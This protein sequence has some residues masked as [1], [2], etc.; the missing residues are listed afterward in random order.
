VVK[1]LTAT[2]CGEPIRDKSSQYVVV[3]N[4][5]GI[6]S[7]VFVIQ[8]FAYK[9]WAKMEYGLD[10]WFTLLTIL[11]GVPTT[12]IN[13]HGVAPN[14]MGR[15][16]WTLTYEN[17][18]DFGRFFYILEIIYFA[19]V[20]LSKLAILFFYIRIFPSSGVRQVLWG[21]VVFVA[22]FGVAFIFSAIF[23]C[24]PIE[25]YWWKWDGVHKGRCLDINAIAWSNA[26][27]SIV[28]DGWMLGIP[29]W[30]LRTL[31]LDWR[32]KVG[33]GLMFGVGTL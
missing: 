33:V 26:A 7:A 24:T 31:N 3:S 18:T 25:Y 17:I 2:S 11:V 32:K 9:Y 30:Q 1:N 20:S 16:A 10:D 22:L 28:L 4:T 19:E 12:V 14:G 29:L 8:R 13:A 5:F 23:Q 6:I 15:D 21:T 27:I